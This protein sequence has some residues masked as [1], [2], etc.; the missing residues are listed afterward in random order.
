MRRSLLATLAALMRRHLLATLAMLALLGPA[1]ADELPEWRHGI[2]VPKSDAGIVLM[3]A[4]GGFA[5]RQGVDLRITELKDDPGLLRALL[6][7]DVDSIEGGPG[8]AI[9]AA[10][11]GAAVR[12]LGCY[13]PVLPHGIFVRAD[14]AQVSDLRGRTFA[15]AGPSGAPDL[16]ARALLAK[17]GIPRDSVRFA[18]LGGDSDR[19]KAL[20]AGVVDATVVSLEYVPLAEKS[21]L[22]LLVAARDVLPQ[23]M[24]TCIETTEATITRRRPALVAFLTAEIGALRFAMSHRTETLALTREVTRIP[25]DDPRPGFIYDDTRNSGSLDTEMNV[26]M[27]KLVWLQDQLLALGNLQHKMDLATLVDLSVRDAAL[28]LAGPK[29]TP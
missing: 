18:D 5:R 10:A 14:I 15:I 13:W 9:L 21:G 24:R 3:N 29:E 8:I 1:R 2:F 22:K 27:D 26:P 6:S 28:R 11:H 23:Y 4:N 16:V 7:G 20:A 17:Y 12:V 25:A 19:Y